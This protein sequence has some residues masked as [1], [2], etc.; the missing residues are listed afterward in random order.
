VMRFSHI[1]NPFLMGSDPFFSTSMP[2]LSD[3]YEDCMTVAH[4]V[5]NA[6]CTGATVIAEF[7]L[8]RS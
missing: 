3:F 6:E 5:R 1:P 8:P 2:H 4:A 7:V